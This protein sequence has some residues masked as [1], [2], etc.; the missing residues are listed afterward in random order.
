M[1]RSPLNRKPKNFWS[2]DLYWHLSVRH[3]AN[4]PSVLR[5]MRPASL[6]ACFVSKAATHKAT[7]GQAT[8]ALLRLRRLQRPLRRFL[9]FMRV[10]NSRAPSSSR[11]SG[12][13]LMLLWMKIQTALYNLS[14]LSHPSQSPP[15]PQ[16]SPKQNLSQ[17]PSQKFS[18]G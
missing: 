18:H 9:R 16:N 10:S 3:A 13:A 6:D 4:G 17:W 14:W 2:L 11:R 7:T 8:Y 15:S 12:N 1:E 5:D